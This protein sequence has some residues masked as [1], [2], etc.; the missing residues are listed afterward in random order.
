M[1]DQS[2]EVDGEAAQPVALDGAKATGRWRVGLAVGLAAAGLG[3]LATN[4]VLFLSSIV[5]FAYAGY[6]YVNTP[7]ETELSIERLIDPVRPVPGERVSVVLTVENE[8][9][10]PVADFRIADGVPD[11]LA[12][13][14]GVSRG[15]FT[16]KPGET[17][18]VEYDVRA[19]R[20]EYE[21][22]DVTVEARDFSGTYVDLTT[23]S[24][25]GADS[26]L[27]CSDA[28]DRRSL[29]GATIQY[30]GRVDTDTG[31]DGL[32]FYATRSYQPSDPMSR[33]DWNRFARTR[34]LTTVELRE[35]RATA[36]V[37]VVD[38]RGTNEVSWGPGEP[39]GV[40]LSKRAASWLVDS[41]LRENNRVGLALYGGGGHY[42]L[43]RS[44]RDQRARVE[45][46]VEGDWCGSFGRPAWLAAG[47]GHVDRFC[48]HVDDDV[49]IVFVS[50]FLDEPPMRSV[51][52][53]GAFGH[54]V[55]VLA[56]RIAAAV[57]TVGT[58]E[59]IEHDRRLRR[60]RDG[61]ARVVEWEPTEPLAVATE[62][63]QRRW[64]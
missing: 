25:G 48:R 1:S 27:V 42:L 23:V 54:D 14:D 47:D 10:D 13:I 22:G 5:G 6:G 2:E 17:A 4:A 46:L 30:T 20:G 62:R 61:G 58:V 24:P 59:R 21:F 19:R 41:L 57:G 29:N 9:L 43:P 56:P 44:G 11:S 12:V 18:T 37:V 26:G 8:G 53:F 38:V 33:V 36:V 45:R 51:G 63:A 64:A 35:E 31:G 28:R 15:V 16:L 3:I 49:Q 55:T 52:R 39:D 40:D 50:P 60:L 32:E 7:H 34:E